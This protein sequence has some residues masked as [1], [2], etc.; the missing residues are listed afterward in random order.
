MALNIG[1]KLFDYLG[2]GKQ[3]LAMVPPG[4]A[5]D[6]LSELEWGVVADPDP[7]SVADA[8]ARIVDL[9]RPDRVPDPERRYDREVLAG[10]LA[11][12]LDRVARQEP[13][14]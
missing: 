1:G 4:D 10:R 5:R 13:N 3:I 8:I 2:Q 14:P 12:L 6:V 9:P 7:A 11:G